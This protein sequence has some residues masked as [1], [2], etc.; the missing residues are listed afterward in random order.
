MR[1]SLFSSIVL[2]LGTL[3][4]AA[5]PPS[6]ARNVS[7]DQGPSES[8][9]VYTR[10]TSITAPKPTD[11]DTDSFQDAE[12][13][14]TTLAA[15]PIGLPGLPSL[16]DL[17]P[18]RALCRTY[19]VSNAFVDYRKFA[20]TAAVPEDKARKTCAL[21]NDHLRAFF[22]CIFQRDDVCGLEDGRFVWRTTPLYRRCGPGSVESAWW[23]TTRN[24]YGN[25]DCRREY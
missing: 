13:T 16:P 21:L 6:R 5:P 20:V 3:T 10:P 22:W 7:L 8:S 9:P 12:D 2:A 25:I 1:L 23:Q 4:L 24:V 15:L 19:R 17:L 11:N 14:N 18:S